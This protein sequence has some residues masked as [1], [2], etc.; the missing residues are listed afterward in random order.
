MSEDRLK[1]DLLETI[2]SHFLFNFSNVLSET[3]HAEFFVMSAIARKCCMNT[4]RCGV[5]DLADF[6]RVSSP[7]VSRM[8][9]S[10]EN[11]GYVER[12]TDKLNR[13]STCVRLTL[14]GRQ[15]YES[16]KSRLYAFTAGITQRMGEDKVVSLIRLSEELFENISDELEQWSVNSSVVKS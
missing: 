11:R 4:E 14:S 1:S 6:L 15:V 13:R 9:T 2:H 16:E 10:L 5:S 7:A 12:Y 3:S 8:I